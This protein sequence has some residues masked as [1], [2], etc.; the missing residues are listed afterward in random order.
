[1]R[2]GL[3]LS[4]FHSTAVPEE[5]NVNARRRQPLVAEHASAIGSREGHDDHLAAPDLLYVT[6]DVF[7]DAD[8]F[9][10]HAL[11]GLVRAAT[12]YGQRSLPQMQARVTRMVASVGF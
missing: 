7:N 12:W 4:T 8:G 3:G 9:V 2:R 5:A 11:T 6:A 10:A 1:M